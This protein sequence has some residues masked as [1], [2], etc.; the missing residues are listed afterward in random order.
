MKKKLISGLVAATIIFGTGYQAIGTPLADG[1]NSIESVKGQ[2]NEVISKVKDLEGKVDEINRKIEPV[3]FAIEDNKEKIGAVEKEVEGTLTQIEESKEE[4]ASK[5]KVLDQRLRETYKS[6]TRTNFI[7][8]LLTSR[9]L[10][11]FLSNIDAIVRVVNLDK[12]FIDELNN[13]KDELD[14]SIK[15]LTDKKEQLTKLNAENEVK[16]TELNEMKNKEE[17]LLNQLKAEKAQIGD[18][19]T[20]LERPLVAQDISV[21]NNSNSSKEQLTSAINSLSALKGQIISPSIQTEINNAISAAKATIKKIEEAEK[22]PD[23]P[24]APSGNAQAII[25]YAYQFVGCNYVLGA[26]GPSAFDCSG[27]TQFVFRKFG[28][29]LSRTTYTQVNQGRAVSRSELQPGDLVFTEGN[30]PGHVGI[31][32]GNGQMVHAA[33][34]RQGVIVGPIYHYTTARRIL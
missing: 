32:V 15:G 10:N 1:N 30:P 12:N 33:N 16:L 8:M 5:Q 31:Y 9:D 11:D 7:A 26:T 3:F 29:N 24:E 28:Y 19:L 21:A 6:G 2:Y 23:I 34:S 13:K 17:V 25:N 20:D 4:I 27:F 14:N 22:K 18:K